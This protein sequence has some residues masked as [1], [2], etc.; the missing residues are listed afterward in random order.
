M[1][2]TIRQRITLLAIVLSAGLLAL[3]AVVMVVVLRSQL[4]DNLDESLSQRADTFAAVIN[5]TLPRELPGDEDLLV[6]VVAADGTIVGRSPNLAG[7]ASIGPRLS[8]FHTLHIPGRRERFRVLARLV[9]RA[10]GPVHLT[11][12]VN[13][14]HV[15]DPVSILTRLLLATMPPLVALLGVLVWWLTGRTLRPVDQM[16]AEMAE[17]GETN[18]GRR[19]QEPAT[20]DE[21]DRLARTMNLTLD[22]LEAAVRKQQ[23]FVADASHELRTP[24]TRI[25]SELEVDLA[26]PATADPVATEQSV[27]SETIALQQLVDDLL[28]VARID[29]E[30]ATVVNATV[31]L[32]DVVLREVR[33]LTDNGRVR[34]DARQVSAAQ[35]QGDGAQLGRALRNVLDNAE[36]HAT[37]TVTVTLAERDEHV[38]L[39]VADDG[40]GIAP[41]DRERVFDRFARLDQ[42]RARDAGG[43]GLGLAIAR[44]IV[45]RHNGTI[46]LADGPTTCF[47]ISLPALAAAANGG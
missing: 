25:R 23:R 2:R 8:G 7:M 35:V 37:S 26:R 12:G 27:L 30:S 29:G 28:R 15:T 16:R 21:I 46:A 4:T 39:T 40:A 42:A 1:P 45:A 10:D 43:T 31:D 9:E 6:Q 20:G 47:V 5:G 13:Y 17:I 41:D 14:D 32:D 36:R 34:V 19:L 44:D 18:L 3:L 22:R 38:R 11:V 24:L 33:R